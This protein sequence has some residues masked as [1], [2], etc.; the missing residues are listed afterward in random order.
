MNELRG[1]ITEL[2]AANARV[3]LFMDPDSAQIQ[4]AARLGVERVE[5]YT[6]PYADTWGTESGPGV[7]ETF[8]AA[9]EAAAAEGLVL[10]AG[11]DLNLD[12]LEQFATVPGLAE[13]SIG[14]AIISDALFRGLSTVVADYKS[15]LNP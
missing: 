10:N 15:I 6:G 3:S 5:L 13:V 12:N 11:H 14:H 8:H 7:F 4:R 2:Q 9:A 1:A